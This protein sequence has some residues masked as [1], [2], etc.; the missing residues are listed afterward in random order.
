MKKE[1]QAIKKELR[2][3][4]FAMRMN[5]LNSSELRGSFLISVFGMAINNTAFIIL[6]VFFVLSVGEINGWSAADIVGLLGFGAASFGV[7]FSLA[8]GIRYM[9][10]YVTT[11]G[12]DRYLVSPKNI[13]IRVATS[14]L[15]IS[16][17]G[18]LLFGIICLL[19]YLYLIQAAFSQFLF[20]CAALCIA[21]F[22]WMAASISIYSVGFFFTDAR[23][24]VWGLLDLF[25]SPSIFH[26]GAFQGIM[27]VVFL[28]IVPSLVVGAFPVE[29]VRESSFEKLLLIAVISI[30][31][32]ILSL[33]IFRA[34]IK[35][36]ESAS[37]MTFGG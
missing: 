28:I 17:L 8:G 27:R 19:I 7:V 9:T 1:I 16:A 14:V 31:W 6:W 5:F 26:G 36:Y 21:I 23:S 12:F 13:L 15:H 18:D 20:L 30:S 24:L 3:G 37:F 4:M 2:F 33:F 35:K 22:M 32:F 25:L 34:G 11:G 29:I 10:E